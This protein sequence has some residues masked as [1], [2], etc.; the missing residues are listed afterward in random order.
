MK[1]SIFHTFWD[2]TI[3]NGKSFLTS[4][5]HEKTSS[6][7]ICVKMFYFLALFLSIQ[8]FS[9]NSQFP[10]WSVLL[11]SEHFFKPIWSVVWLKYVDWQLGIN[12][13]II[14]FFISAVLGV[15]FWRKLRFIR[16]MLFVSMFLYLSLISSF[17]KID[18]W[19]HLM[20]ISSFFLIFIPNMAEAKSSADKKTLLRLI[21]GIQSFILVTYFMS[22]CFKFLGILKQEVR[23]EVSALDSSSLGIFSAMSSYNHNAEIVLTSF[24]IKN[25]TLFSPILLLLAFCVELFSIF[26]LY[27]PKYHSI[28]G[29]LLILL[30]SVILI[31]IGPDFKIQILAV[32]VFLLFSPFG[33]NIDIDLLLNEI[34]GFFKSWFS[35]EK[36]SIIIFYDSSC[37]TCNYF[38]Q[39]VAKFNL[40]DNTC[41]SSQ[42]SQLFLSFLKAYPDLLCLDTIII[43]EDYGTE[44][45]KIR[46]KTDAVSSFLSKLKIICITL[47]I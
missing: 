40:P 35:S 6:A 30:H 38:L 16:V 39:F 31:I 37:I 1:K 29:L 33:R 14:F 34:S 32:G 15:I 26:T 2:H 36:K 13:L 25:E 23:G 47:I 7:L 45:Q 9:R 22:G 8:T 43:V 11:E 18:H 5:L 21:F 4:N 27:K 42:N 28:V 3:V 20:T 19:M 44:K 12:F 41:I 17:G 10:K 46:V 24:I